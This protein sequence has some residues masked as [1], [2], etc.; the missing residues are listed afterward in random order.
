M[1]R[2]PFSEQLTVAEFRRH[3]WYKAELAGICKS[4]G[5]SPQGTKAEM[6]QRVE[7]FLSGE[8]IAD[9][10][11]SHTRIRKKASPREITPQT[12]LIPEGFKFNRQAREFFARYYGKERFSF[13]KEMAAALREAERTGNLEMTVADLIRVYEVKTD[14]PAAASSEEATYQWNRFVRD[15]NAD[16]ATRGIKDRM[17]TAALLWKRVRDDPGWSKTYS[18][19]YLADLLPA[20]ELDK[21]DEPDPS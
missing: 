14:A 9:A 18:T 15:F 19:T 3:Y 6:Q 21:K 2:P 11:E 13:T 5:L 1:E 20:S 7:G 16:P 17:K 8:T 10:R 12:R 4:I